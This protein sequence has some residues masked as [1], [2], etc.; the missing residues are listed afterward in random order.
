LATNLALTNIEFK[1]T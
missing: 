1:I